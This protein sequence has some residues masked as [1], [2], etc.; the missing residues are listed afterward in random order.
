MSKKYKLKPG[1]GLK[2]AACGNDTFDEKHVEKDKGEKWVYVCDSCT[3]MMQFKSEA[4]E[5][6]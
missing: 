1:I 6:K 2:C 4:K 3:H 5:D